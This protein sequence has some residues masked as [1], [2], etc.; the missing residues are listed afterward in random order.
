MEFGYYIRPADTYEGMVEMARYADELG[1][2]GVFLNDHVHS[3]RQDGMGPY[4]EAWT[5]MAGIGVQT[6]RIRLGHIVLFNSLRN[7]AFLAKSVSTLDRMSGGRYELLIG[8]GWN[9]PE[10][11]GYDLMER[12]RGMPSAGERADRFKETLQIL[13]GMFDNDVFSYEGKYWTLR[14]AINLPLPVQRPMRISVG[15]DKPRMIRIAAKYAD[16]LNNG[17]GLDSLGK[18]RELLVP[19][20]ERNGKRLEDY[21][22]SGFAAQVTVN[23]SDEEYESMAKRIAERS[24]RSVEDVKG[25]VFSGT[26]EA[27]VEKFRKA[28]DLGV[29]MMVVYIRPASTIEEMKEELSRFND[30]VIKEI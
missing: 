15:A 30:E 27:L 19:A 17:G 22:F 28:E 1:L 16:G 4:L 29:K 2:F 7:P 10:Y 21:Y 23:E 3:M 24:K 13:R 26:S 6:K 25:D 14:D 11:L 20:L 5:A 12:G 8:A 9:E 18:I